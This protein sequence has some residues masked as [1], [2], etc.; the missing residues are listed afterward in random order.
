MDHQNTVMNLTADGLRLYNKVQRGTATLNLTRIVVGD[1]ELAENETAYD[2]VALKRAVDAV[3]EIIKNEEIGD[4]TTRLTIRI[5]SSIIDYYL[6]EIGIIAIDPDEGEILYAYCNFGE[7]ADYIRTF[8][9]TVATTQEIEIYIQIGNAPDMIV[10]VTDA[11]MVTPKDLREHTENKNNPHDVTAEQLGL[12]KMLLDTITQQRL[13]NYDAAYRASHAHANADI[14]NAITQAVI[15]GWNAGYTHSTTKGNP[16]NTSKADI[17]LGNVTNESKKTMFS[18][19]EFTGKPKAP[20]AAAGTSTTQIATTEF[21][22][23]AIAA[24]ATTTLDGTY[25]MYLANKNNYGTVSSLGRKI[26][27]S[28]YENDGIYQLP[29]QWVADGVVLPKD[30]IASVISGV[31]ITSNDDETICYE[32]LLYS[33]GEIWSRQAVLWWYQGGATGRYGEW[34]NN[35]WVNDYVAPDYFKNN[36]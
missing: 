10:N 23:S 4:G 35:E 8:N 6:R 5:L 26:T 32:M 29:P 28:Q 7:Y 34:Q 22:M 31:T 20:T 1:G 9:G 13:L 18:S 27:L 21:V 17:G 19:P 25:A 33:N 16:H 12:N 11:L 2:L 24:F 30:T 14:L 3:T 15:A 36:I